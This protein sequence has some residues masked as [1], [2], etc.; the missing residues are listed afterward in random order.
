[1]FQRFQHSPP[2][3]LQDYPFPLSAPTNGFRNKLMKES[4]ELPLLASNNKLTQKQIIGNFLYYSISVHGEIITVPNKLESVQ[5]KG[6]D[7]TVY[8]M[9]YLL[10]YFAT[11]PRVILSY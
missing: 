8:I 4:G 10:N 11:Y 9:K 1:M 2:L 7:K 3:W 5:G 6:T